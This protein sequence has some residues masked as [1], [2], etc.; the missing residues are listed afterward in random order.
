MSEVEGSQENQPVRAV[1]I[2]ASAVLFRSF[3][4]LPPMT[5]PTSEPSHALFG[6]AKSLLKLLHEWKPTHIIALMDGS[7]AKAKRQQIYPEYKAHREETPSDLLSQ[8]KEARALCEALGVQVDRRDDLEADDLIA[9]YTR[10]FLEKASPEDRLFI[11]S[12]DKDLLQLLGEQVR[13][14]YIPKQY[15]EMDSAAVMEKLGVEPSQVADYLAIVGDASDNIPGIS[16]IGP[17]G[18]SALLQE[19]ESLEGIY[20]AIKS[21]RA[22]LPEK[23][24]EK[25]LMQEEIAFISQ[26]LTQLD[27]EA[28][29]LEGEKWRFNYGRQPQEW[30][31]FCRKWGFASCAEGAKKIFAQNGSGDLQK[32]STKT[33]Q[34]LAK[35]LSQETSNETEKNEGNR[36][37]ASSYPC[38]EQIRELCSPEQIVQELEVVWKHPAL[39]RYKSLSLYVCDADLICPVSKEE[40]FEKELSFEMIPAFASFLRDP[41]RELSRELSR[42]LFLEQSFSSKGVGFW[43]TPCQAEAD[44][45]YPI[46]WHL[47]ADTAEGERSLLQS[48][49]KLLVEQLHKKQ[50]SLSLVGWETK[51]FACALEGIHL[52]ESSS[53]KARD[54]SSVGPFCFSENEQRPKSSF[55]ESKEW[56][57]FAP[58]PKT[59]HSSPSD[60][61]E[62]TPI[63]SDEHSGGIWDLSVLV[64]LLWSDPAALRQSF[65]CEHFHLQLP[66]KRGLSCLGY[67]R[68]IKK[69]CFEKLEKEKS[70]Q[71]LYVEIEN[72]LGRVLS[73]IQ[74]EGIVCCKNELDEQGAGIR[75]QL[76]SLTKQIQ[77]HIGEEINLNSPKQLAQVLFEKLQIKPRKKNKTGFSTNAQ[78]LKELLGQHPVIEDLLQYRQL[79]K[80]RST[81]LDSL[82]EHIEPDGKIHATL[83]QKITSTG[84]LSC[85]APNL[86]NIPI[87]QPLG[88]ALRRAFLPSH[89]DHCLVSFDYSQIELRLLA[90]FSKDPTLLGA[91]NQTG[92]DVH[93]ATAAAIHQIAPEKVSAEQRSFAKAVNFGIIYGQ[94]AFGLAKQ[95]EISQ[96]EAKEFIARYF[97]RYG[98]I[99]TYLDSLKDSALDLG[100]AQTLCGRR[101]YIPQ[102]KSPNHQ[103]RSAGQRIAINTPIQGSAADIIKKAMCQI[104]IEQAHSLERL[105]ALLLLQI[106]DELLFSVPKTN[107]EELIGLVKPQMEEAALLRCPLTVNVKI[108]NNWEEC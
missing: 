35:G 92:E 72:P 101:R 82:I 23:K 77:K 17:K 43:L 87:R 33:S 68:A 24:K 9:S 50:C 36:E 73:L 25:F 107:V 75:L 53:S 51:G 47:H 1:L 105:Q 15:S 63:L 6:F 76:E 30:L 34:E 81:Y 70:L 14:I 48:F 55:E 67:L 90:H 19:F 103:I 58:L 13:M 54:S 94:S 44:M 28:E 41:S 104:A 21:G 39:N 102:I 71:S 96:S 83:D 74:Q 91:F 5:S 95:L 49:F 29:V 78:T 86:Q 45:A 42:D 46:A 69:A 4:A 61:K 16:G 100:Y 38:P 60:R 27:G 62:D 65:L 20:A 18:A 85:Y 80:L 108:G 66:E 79:E 31:H 52:Q 8:L 84:R 89:T 93:I 97:E 106:H 99:A 37:P 11:C 22:K 56:D 7:S 59:E 2:D 88:K 10:S 32:T 26:K 64:Y 40:L 98:A 12:Q 57:L 3:F